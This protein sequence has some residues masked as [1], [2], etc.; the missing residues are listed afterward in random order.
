MPTESLPI[1]HGR[2]A[3]NNP[4]NRFEVLHLEPDPDQLP[5]DERPVHPATRYFVDSSRTILASNDSPDVGFT[6]SINPYRGCSHGCIYCYARPTHEYLS[7]SCGL[8]FETKIFVKPDAPNLL[9]SELMKKNWVP[10]T[11]SISGVTDCYQPVERQLR[12]TRSCIEVLTEFRNPFAIV[13]K[14]HLVARDID[15]LSEM[16]SINAVVVMISMTTLDKDLS[17]KMEPQASSP[18]RRLEAMRKLSQAGIPVGVMVAPIIPGLTDHGIPSLLSA[19]ADAGA[20]C[21]GHV[22]LRLPYQ[23]KELFA[24]WLE[25][26]F[27]DRADKVLNRIREMRGGKLNNSQFGQRMKGTGVFADQVHAMFQ[28][29]KKRAGLDQKFPSLSTAHFRRPGGQM[30]LF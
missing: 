5:P 4:T 24:H 23:L 19:A 18:S 10:Q 29:A 1:L 17:M 20:R 27:P 2:G 22:M 25:Q 15:L 14:S 12:L 21:A 7:L 6:C 13:T 16:S 3:S 30:P 28:L 26:H 8:D 11:I 9:R